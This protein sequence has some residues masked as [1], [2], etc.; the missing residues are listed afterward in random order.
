MVTALL[1]VVA[2]AVFQLGLALYVR[3]T[4]ISAASEGARYGARAFLVGES[5]MREDDVA[6]A[7]RRLLARPMSAAGGL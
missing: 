1:L 4:L 3:N 2:L 7:T 6:A 5:L